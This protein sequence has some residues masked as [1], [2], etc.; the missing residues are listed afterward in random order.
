M[1]KQQKSTGLLAYSFCDQ[2]NFTGGIYS[3]TLEKY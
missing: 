2:L 1:G 3:N